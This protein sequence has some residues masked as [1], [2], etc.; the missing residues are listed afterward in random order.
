VRGGHALK[1]FV[2][3]QRASHRHCYSRKLLTVPEY[4]SILP[5]MNVL[6]MS[7]PGA[8]I[9]TIGPKLDHSISV[10]LKAVAPTVHAL[11]SDAGDE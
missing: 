6:V 11:G 5:P 7:T 10:S 1:T 8:R 9:S 3:S 4:V 2:K